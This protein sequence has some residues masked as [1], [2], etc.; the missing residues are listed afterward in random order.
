MRASYVIAWVARS[1]VAKTSA[2]LAYSTATRPC[3]RS[4][5]LS[6]SATNPTS[7]ALVVNPF[8]APRLPRFGQDDDLGGRGLW[9]YA[10]ASSTRSGWSCPSRDPDRLGL[11]G[12]R[13]KQDE[14]QDQA[15]ERR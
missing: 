15:G 11:E 5:G 4:A 8:L 9:R 1:A 7:T 2:V 13:S 6:V 10:S 12:G 14:A 3:S